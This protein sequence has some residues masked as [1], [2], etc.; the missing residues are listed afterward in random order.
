LTQVRANTK[1]LDHDTLPRENEMT[2]Q[3]PGPDWYPDP[4]GNPGLMYW[5]G[6]QW[7]ADLT[8][9]APPAS[10]RPGEIATAPSPGQRPSL[11]PALLLIALGIISCAVGYVVGIGIA[12]ALGALVLVVGLVLLVIA[13][14][15]ALR[16][17]LSPAETSRAPLS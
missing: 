3:P 1:V 16:D 5:D 9:A 13:I 11:L 14:L 6:Q 15:R 2:T 8:S 7:H 12:Y 4:T 17:G 10:Q